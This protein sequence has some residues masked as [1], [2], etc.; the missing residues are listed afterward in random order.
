MIAWPIFPA[1]HLTGAKTGLN[2]AELKPTYNTKTYTTKLNTE[3]RSNKTKVWSRGPLQ[4]P[5][6]KQIRPILQLPGPVRGPGAQF[7]KILGKFLSLAYQV[8]PKSV[9]SMKLRFPKIFLSEFLESDLKRLPKV[10]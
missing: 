5:A 9:L 8:L 3:T 2:Q 10:L 7:T 6:S 1:N 4:R